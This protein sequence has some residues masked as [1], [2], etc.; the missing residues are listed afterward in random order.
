M[1]GRHWAIPEK[2]NGGLRT[3]FFEPLEFL[4]FLYLRDFQQITFVTLNVTKILSVKQPSHPPVLNGQYQDGQNANQNQMGNRCPFYIIF[5]VLKV[6]HI[7][8][9]RIKPPDL[10]FLVFLG[11]TSADIIFHKFLELHLTL[12]EKKI[13][14]TNF[15][16]LTDLFKPPTL[17]A[18]ICC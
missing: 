11:F 9:C 16:F 14:V 7:K 15:P 8:I 3:Y 18:K 1:I 17:I 5:Q 6:L 13:F 10:L 4:G 2:R 12:S